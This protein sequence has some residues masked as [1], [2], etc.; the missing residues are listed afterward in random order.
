MKWIDDQ[1][2]KR[3]IPRREL[4]DHIGLTESQ[5]SKVMNGTRRLTAEEADAI[6]RYFGYRLPDDPLDAEEQA[7]QERL[8]KLGA[9]QKRAVVL[10]LEAL[11]DNDRSQNR[12][13]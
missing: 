12:A 4:A 3:G 10:Y 13:F 8:S 7:I 11:L 6:R 2:E 9:G 1:L 5:M